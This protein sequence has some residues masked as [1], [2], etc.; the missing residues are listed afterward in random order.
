VSFTR[1]PS[2]IRNSALFFGVD[3]IVYVEGNGTDQNF[4]KNVFNVFYSG[5]LLFH[6]KSLGPRSAVLPYAD[7]IVNGSISNVVAIVDSDYEGLRFSKFR[8]PN[9]IYSHGYSFENDLFTPKQA[10]KLISQLSGGTGISKYKSLL[11]RL[12]TAANE[13]SK[14][15]VLDFVAQFN[16]QYLLEK[17]GN[18]CRL[19][20]KNSPIEVI[21][22]KSIAAAKQNLVARGAKLKTRP[23]K[24]LRDQIVAPPKYRWVYG[25]LWQATFTKCVADELRK[26]SS[27]TINPDGLLNLAISNILTSN[28]KVFTPL[29]IFEY[30]NQISII[31]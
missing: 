24:A 2:G 19:H 9:V 11:L 14:L 6:F 4:W 30:Q 31:R 25:H 10:I 18:T 3:R 8:I 5:S 20:I 17:N 29:Q 28:G 13:L 27:V 16:D 22:N 7:G 12:K 23:N 15:S 26:K 1:S 21:C